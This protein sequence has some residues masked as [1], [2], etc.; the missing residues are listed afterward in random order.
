MTSHEQ[1]RQ[2]IR[3]QILSIVSC[4]LSLL[5]LAHT[6]TLT[7]EFRPVALVDGLMGEGGCW[8]AGRVGKRFGVWL[9]VFWKHF[10]EGLK[11]IFKALLSDGAITV[12]CAVI[13]G[14]SQA[15]FVF[16]FFEDWLEHFTW[17][18]VHHWTCW[19]T[20]L[21]QHVLVGWLSEGTQVN[22]CSAWVVS[23]ASVN[24]SNATTQTFACKGLWKH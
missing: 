19:I 14:H 11:N 10:G 21:T 4:D 20:I 6:Q 23:D 24:H 16:F 22:F 7:L 18:F 17:H 13:N 1:Q 2:S 8:L 12:V 15:Q 5:S 3:I 9:R